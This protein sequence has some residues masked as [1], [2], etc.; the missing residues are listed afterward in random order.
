MPIDHSKKL[1]A[2][3]LKEKIYSFLLARDTNG[4]IGF[5]I[6]Y[7]SS[8]RVADMIFISNGYSYAIEIKSEIDSTSRLKGQLKEYQS[9]F[10][11][12]LIF[13]APKHVKK[14]QSEISKDIG[15]Y[16]ISEVAIETVQRE[17]FNRSAQKSE[18]LI[19]IPS[20]AVKSEFSI[21]G[22]LTSDEIRAQALHLS[23]KVIHDY[24]IDY[25]CQKLTKSP[26]SITQKD[27]SKLTI[28]SDDY[29]IV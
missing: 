9:L 20:A 21:K 18:M 25:Y 24:F 12:I 17:K 1:N 10:D 15:L 5:E 29:M 14:I 19:S 16:S 7:G 22:K 6:M 3:A 13:S 23:K 2:S 4:V 8:R 28:I 26:T 11:Y 27:N